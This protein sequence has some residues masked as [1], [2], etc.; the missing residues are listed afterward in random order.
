LSL[1]NPSTGLTEP[2]PLPADD[3][4]RASATPALEP[5]T[6][7]VGIGSAVEPAPAPSQLSFKSLLREI[8]ETIILTVLIYAVV[9]FATG[10]F[11]VE[12]S[13]MEPSVHP[14][15]Y[16]LVDK[17]SYRLG[18]PQRGDVVVFNYPLATERD[19]I[20]RVIGLPGETVTVASG[21]VSVN[22]Q[23]LTEPYIAAPPVSAGTWQLGANE[24]F[25]MGDNRNNSS[26]SRS[27]GP[28]ERKYL[29]GK[30]VL[31]YWPPT[32]WGLVPHYTYAS[33]TK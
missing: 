22:G 27:W 18:S 30:A 29:I 5:G 6:A 3:A 8:I 14:N 32:N 2:Q 4:V 9:N 17:I 23:P 20:K 31:T 28:L 25:V 12:G 24:Y 7:P 1:P 33:S 21:V 13:S 16:V 26:D 11:K 19:F 10:R 15:Q